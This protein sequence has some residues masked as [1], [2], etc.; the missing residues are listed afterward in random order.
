MQLV[1]ICPGGGWVMEKERVWTLIANLTFLQLYY[2]QS[3]VLC[4]AE[5][6]QVLAL[7]CENKVLPFKAPERLPGR[8][9]KESLPRVWWSVP[10]NRLKHH[11][12]FQ[13]VRPGKSLAVGSLFCSHLFSF[14]RLSK[15]LRHRG[16]NLELNEDRVG[17]LWWSERGS[18][19]TP[20][21]VVGVWS[22]TVE[23][24][25][26]HVCRIPNRW[27]IYLGEFCVFRFLVNY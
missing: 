22:L 9:R 1:P 14:D 13:R 24:P 19:Q 6:W 16:T 12:A 27:G 3:Y 10:C 23:K 18:A 2:F 17:I 4:T 11:F 21:P 25:G 20:S 5:V 7:Q 26:Q 8:H 15:M